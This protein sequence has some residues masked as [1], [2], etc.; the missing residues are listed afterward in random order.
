[1]AIAVSQ[2]LPVHRD[3]R[4]TKDPGDEEDTKE[5]KALWDLL[6]KV[7]S[8]ASWDQQVLRVMLDSRDKK[9]DIG[10]TGMPGAK[11]EPGESISAPV[12]AVSPQ[13]LTVNEGGSASFK[14]SVSGNPDPVIVWSKTNRQY[15]RSVVSGGKMLLKNVQ[16][17]DSGT[18]NCSVVNILGQAQALVKLI[19]NGKIA[20]T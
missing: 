9:G 2:A 13:T 1:M 3:Q 17:S 19:V 6:E 8:K 20:M 14:C 16:G 15:S 7:G 11:G 10:P 5:T 12:V 4:E 18:Y